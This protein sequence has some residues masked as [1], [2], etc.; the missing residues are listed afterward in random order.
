MPPRCL[1]LF[2]SPVPLRRGT[3]KRFSCLSF[4]VLCTSGFF[5]G[6]GVAARIGFYDWL[7]YAFSWKPPRRVVELF[8]LYRLVPFSDFS[9]IVTFF[10]VEGTFWTSDIFDIF[11]STAFCVI[12]PLLKAVP[13][14]FREASLFL[15]S[16]TPG[17]YC[18]LRWVY[19]VGNWD[20]S[21]T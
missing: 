4:E 6:V 21:I 12:G 15:E 19:S 17:T 8:L 16:L 20:P 2:T 10:D 7:L 5:S 18:Y 3:G 9:A 13:V 14:C 1:I 11:L